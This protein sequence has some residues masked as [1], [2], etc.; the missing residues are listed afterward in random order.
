MRLQRRVLVYLAL[1]AIASCTLTVAVG[2]VL[3]RRQ[4]ASQRLTALT[5]QADLIAAAGGP[6]AAL[7]PGDHVYR[8]GTGR[9]RKVSRL[10]AA[11]VLA[12]IPT[13]GSGQGTVDVAGRSLM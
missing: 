13:S 4:V 2:V 1:V 6:A 11:A 9:A 3:V 10:A 7:Q 12:A 8:V 5:G